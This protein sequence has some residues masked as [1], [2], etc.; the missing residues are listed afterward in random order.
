MKT[1]YLVHEISKIDDIKYYHEESI[2]A[3][4]YAERCM[5]KLREIIDDEEI[6]YSAEKV[7]YIMEDMIAKIKKI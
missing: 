4:K 7:N 2:T 3:L 6:E 5:K 1:V